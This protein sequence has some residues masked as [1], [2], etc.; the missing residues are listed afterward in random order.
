MKR[1]GIATVLLALSLAPALA[2]TVD[3]AAG[4]L[5]ILPALSKGTVVQR[6]AAANALNTG[7]MLDVVKDEKQRAA[8]RAALIDRVLV[9]KD[10]IARRSCAND[11]IDLLRFTQSP[12]ED[13][14]RC[15][16]L[17]TDPDAEV[18]ICFLS[19]LSERDASSPPLNA[20]LRTRLLALG[21]HPKL[22]VQC[23][24]MRWAANES[25]L[26]RQAPPLDPFGKEALDMALKLSTSADLNTSNRALLVLTKVYPADP[27]R[28]F[29]AL[30][31]RIEKA[32]SGKIPSPIVD[33][34][35]REGLAFLPLQP[36]LLALYDK[37]D[38]PISKLFLIE[39]LSNM[40]PFPERVWKFL[41]SKAAI[42]P[43]AD[44]ASA[45]HYREQMAI[46]LEHAAPQ[47]PAARGMVTAVLPHMADW[48]EHTG[49]GALAYPL[50]KIGVTPAQVPLVVALARKSSDA[51][52]TFQYLAAIGWS[53]TKEG[54]VFDFLRNRLKDGS[55]AEQNGAAY[56]LTLLGNSRDEVQDWVRKIAWPRAQRGE[57]IDGFLI[58][59]VRR[60]GMKMPALSLT[61]NSVPGVTLNALCSEP[62]RQDLVDRLHKALKQPAGVH[63]FLRAYADE[64][65]ISLTW[66][67]LLH[68]EQNLPG[69]AL[70]TQDGDAR[71]AEAARKA[72]HP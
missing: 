25:R 3:T 32:P 14:A 5:Q 71:L 19:A 57:N 7:D 13:F 15:F 22:D 34:A 59:V 45:S 65:E 2:Q 52:V 12:N 17:F 24:M 54:Q 23:E 37:L 11:L 36:A 4:V 6:R 28:V 46:L 47:G 33:A 20:D 9:E 62:V 44:P 55:P 40:G 69:L 70:L 39:T 67:S 27:E 68:D 53:G 49:G 8:V 48:D 42:A 58:G 61:E 21:T 10:A 35:T 50:A 38:D 43:P 51:R 63:V 41:E 60:Q 30:K 56:A 18:R 64:L 31:I 26:A 72:L 29:P 16:P 1:T 66:L